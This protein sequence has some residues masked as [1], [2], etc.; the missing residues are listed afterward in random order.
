MQPILDE[1]TARQ[2]SAATNYPIVDIS[3][4]GYLD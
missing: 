2:R 4:T 3:P 1:A